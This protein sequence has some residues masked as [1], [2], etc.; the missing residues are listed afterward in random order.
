MNF[1]GDADVVV[2][3]QNLPVLAMF[4]DIFEELCPMS[5]LTVAFM[6]GSHI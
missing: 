6:P 5:L 4:G 3:V 1:G 2:G